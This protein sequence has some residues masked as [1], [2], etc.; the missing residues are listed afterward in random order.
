MKSI[1]SICVITIIA[2]L[3]INNGQVSFGRVKRCSAERERE[4]DSCAAKLNFLGDHS[5]KVPKDNNSMEAFCSSTKDALNCLQGYSKDCLIGFTRQLFFSM[6]KKAKQ[7]VNGICGTGDARKVFM[8]K[9]SCITDNKMKQFYYKLD[10][11]IARFEYIDEK[12]RQDSKIPVL[13]CSYLIF[14]R[15]IESTIGNVC[16]KPNGKPNSSFDYINKLAVEAASEFS[17]M[18]CDT[19]RSFDD[20]KRSDKTSSSLDKLEEVSKKVEAGKLAP[21]AKSLLPILLDILD[22][23]PK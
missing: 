10:A 6:M 3:I 9:M 7:Q 5:F 15:D 19:Y 12:V 20:C 16:G 21:K 13:C 14:V 4:M 1:S 18:M 22:S 8:T 23:S 17:T 11:S 2:I